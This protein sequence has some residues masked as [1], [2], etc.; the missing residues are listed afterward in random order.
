MSWYE[1]LKDAANFVKNSSKA[2]IQ[3]V[4]IDAQQ[5]MLDMQEKMRKIQDENERLKEEN[6]RLITESKGCGD[7]MIYHEELSIVMRSDDPKTPL[8]VCC[9]NEKRKEIRMI[10]KHSGAAYFWTCPSCCNYCRHT[11]L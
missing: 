8:C 6:E 10:K 7:G 3:Q 9:W 1:A 4:L 11:E 2:D 5:Q